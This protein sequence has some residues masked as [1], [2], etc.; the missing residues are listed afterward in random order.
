MKS[1]CSKLTKED[2]SLFYAACEMGKNIYSDS[3]YFDS[4]LE[5]FKKVYYPIDDFISKLIWISF[6]RFE[7][8]CVFVVNQ[9][10]SRNLDINLN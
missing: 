7:K 8:D 2:Q 9:H 10:R 3:E 6:G 4:T 5:N 1:K